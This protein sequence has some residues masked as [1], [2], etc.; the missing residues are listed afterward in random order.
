MQNVIYLLLRRMRL[1]LI[2]L[3]AIY[4][5]SVLGLVLIPGMDDQGN[6]WRMDFFHAIYFVSFLG[7]TIG[8]GEIPYPFTDGQ[9]MWT[10]FIIYAAVI[11]WLYAIGSILT[12]IQD[13]AF[14]R[15]LAFS[16]FARKVRRL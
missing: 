13:K 15:V 7:S 11:S 16:A 4:A 9:R 1:P 5:V 3:I 10:T 8:F 12:L 6:P 14:R 2:V